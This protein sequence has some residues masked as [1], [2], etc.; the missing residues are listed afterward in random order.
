MAFSL[1]RK[2]K[3]ENKMTITLRKEVK[4]IKHLEGEETPY[5]DNLYEARRVAEAQAKENGLVAPMWLLA[6]GYPHGEWYTANSEDVS[7][8]ALSDCPFGKKGEAFVVTLHGGRDGKR[9]LP[10]DVIEKVVTMYRENNETGLT[11]V[12]AANLQDAYGKPVFTDLLNGALPDGNSVDLFSFDQVKAGEHRDHMASFKTFGIVRPL[13][14]AKE[15]ES[16]HHPIDDLALVKDGKIVGAKD[17][18]VIAYT[19]GVAEGGLFLRSAQKKYNKIGVHHRFNEKKFEPE[20][21]QARVLFLYGGSDG[22]EGDFRI[23]VDGRFVVVAPEALD[24]RSACEN[25]GPYRTQA[26]VPPLESRVQDALDASRAFEHNGT[27]Y[28]PVNA[29]NLELKQ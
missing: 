11:G 12:Y 17:S 23:N 9:M 24:A 5:K 8:T 19:G 22:L 27:L 18:Q 3:G 16:C 29:G 10:L 21:E 14:L 1:E 25:G 6:E 4:A 28:V 2:L 7:G 15:T 20:Q 26:A 13:S